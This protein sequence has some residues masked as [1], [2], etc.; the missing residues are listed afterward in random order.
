MTRIRRPKSAPSATPSPVLYVMGTTEAPGQLRAFRS[1]HN[2]L[3]KGYKAAGLN[4]FME[5]RPRAQDRRSAG[6]NA[7][8]DTAFTECC[9]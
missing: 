5:A 9:G 1:T 3:L 2:E 6:A 4:F 8:A 7:R